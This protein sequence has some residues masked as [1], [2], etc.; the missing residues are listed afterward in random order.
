LG[1]QR[2]A[3]QREAV[4]ALHDAVQDSVGDGGVTE[5]GMPVIHRQPAGDDRGLASGP[6]VD[7]LQQVRSRHA[8]DGAHAPVVE[9]QEVGFAQLQQPLA[10]GGLP[11]LRCT[12]FSSRTSLRSLRAWTS[13]SIN[14]ATRSSKL[15]AVMPG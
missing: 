6:V 9:H 2:V 11:Y 8:V 5:P 3:G 1:T 4:V 15:S 12:F 13:W 14:G 7:D 10:E